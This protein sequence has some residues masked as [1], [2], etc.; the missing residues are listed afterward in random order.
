MGRVVRPGG[1]VVIATEYL[2]AEEYQHVEYFNKS[3]VLEYLVNASPQLALVEPIDFSLPPA[4]YLFDSVV[5]WEGVHKTRRHVVLNDGRV[6]WTS[7]MIFL[8]KQG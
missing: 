3:E 7:I 1:L 8:R 5:C 6:Q 4:E 2:L